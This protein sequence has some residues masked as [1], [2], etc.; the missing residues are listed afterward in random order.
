MIDYAWAAGFHEG[1]GHVSSP[2]SGGLVATVSQTNQ[3][4][5]LKLQRMFGGSIYGPKNHGGKDYWVWSLNNAAGTSHYVWSIL[6]WL[7]EEKAERALSKVERYHDR[8][9][10]KRLFCSQGHNKDVVGSR[11]T[12]RGTKCRQ[13]ERD[14]R[15]V[16]GQS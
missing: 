9:A 16:N 14:R 11:P 5:L 8:Q 4:P 15:Q 13:C 3:E 6:P 1:E 2:N 7:S 10:H 12:T